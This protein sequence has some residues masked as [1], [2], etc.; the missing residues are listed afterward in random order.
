M[1]PVKEQAIF[2]GIYLLF[3]FVFLTYLV[4]H[5][6]GRTYIETVKKR[7]KEYVDLTC[8]VPIPVAALSKAWVYGRSLTRIVGSNPPVGMDVCLL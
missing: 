4:L 3:C 1:L 7:M 2:V 5:F 8:R 6:K